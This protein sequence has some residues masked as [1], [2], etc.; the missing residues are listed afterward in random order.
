M[1]FNGDEWAISKNI[2]SNPFKTKMDLMYPKLND[3]MVLDAGSGEGGKALYFSEVAR[4]I[5]G[6]ELDSERLGLSISRNDK[7]NVNFSSGNLENLEFEDS[8]FDVIYSCWVVEHLENPQKCF[9]E[10][11]R[12]LKPGG[13]LILW[14]P[15]VKSFMGSMIK[16]SP[17]WLKVKALSFFTKEKEEDVSNQECFYRANSVKKLDKLLS[18]KFKRALLHREDY[19]GYYRKFRFLTYLWYVKHKLTNNIFLRWLQPS[20]YV[21]YKKIG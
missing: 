18:G 15:N 4:K 13:L 16:Y 17:H 1:S 5:E 9:D 11:Y 6:I 19:P 3:K 14:V 8:Y 10:F 2:I 7:K 21:E 20:F 12:V